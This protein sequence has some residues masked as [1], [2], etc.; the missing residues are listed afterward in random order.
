MD[1]FRCGY[2][3]ILG[4][5]NVGKSS[6]M[7]QLLG[8]TLCATTHLPQTTRHSILGILNCNQTQLLF[9]DTPGVIPD[10]AYKLQSLMLDSVSTSLRNADVAIWVTDIRSPDRLL[11]DSD[12]ESIASVLYRELNRKRLIVALNKIDALGE[13]ERE[14]RI[15]EAV[16]SFRLLFPEAMAILPVSAKTPFHPGVTALR[17]I[18]CNESFEEISASVRNM[19]RPFPGMF[20]GAR[21]FP[22]EEEVRDLIPRT[23]A[24]LYGYDTDLLTDRNERFLASEMIREALFRSRLEKEVP[25]CCEVQIH[26]F[27]DLPNLLKIKAVI[28]VERDSQKRIVVGKGGNQIKDIGIR[29]RKTIEQFYR[30]KVHLELFVKVQPGWRKRDDAL[31]KFGY[32]S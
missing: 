7:N 6:L 8:E 28:F 25:Y 14:Q 22:T 20:R 12:G 24:P 5:P 27:K 16:L 30:K 1:A 26:S 31:K 13:D 17:R 32:V 29:A 2:I 3:S 15:A 23:P 4:L 10:P 19:G 9:L 11:D 18:L 21:V